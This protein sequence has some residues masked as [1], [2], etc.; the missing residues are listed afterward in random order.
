MTEK[1]PKKHFGAFFYQFNRF[2][3]L[4]LIDSFI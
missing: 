1:S 4:D 3:R 2:K